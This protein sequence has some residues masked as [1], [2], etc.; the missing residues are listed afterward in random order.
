MHS[1]VTPKQA[2]EAANRL[3]GYY[4]VIQASDQKAFV[5]G[6]VQLFSAYDADHVAMAVD[7]VHGLP[8]KHKFM[9][10]LAEVRE[11][12]EPLRL[13]RAAKEHEQKARLRQLENRSLE[14][15]ASDEMRGRIR[16]GFEEL[17]NK[18]KAG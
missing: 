5:T 17:A 18:L 1:R 14:G 8:G 2:S 10:N 16:A 6:L 3:L 11:F 4:P 13:D 12:L 7:V 15:P 9:P